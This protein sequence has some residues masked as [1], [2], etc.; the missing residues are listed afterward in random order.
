MSNIWMTW[1]EV[2]NVSLQ[3][4]WWG[5]IQFAPKLILAIIFFVIGWIL[6]SLITK[7]FEQVFSAL[8]IDNLFKSLGVDD[9]F[10]KAGMNLNSGHFVGEVMKWF[11]IIIFLL[12]S[13]NLIGLDSIAYFLK[14]DV[15]G[16][17]PRIVIAAFVLIIA[18]MVADFLSK[19][20][21]ASARAMNLKSS[22]MLSSLVKYTVWVFAFIIALGQLGVAEGYMSILF[23]GII[24]MLAIGGAL[25]FGLGGK[26]A[27]A[28]LISKLGEEMSHRE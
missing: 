7:A 28:R 4:L 8:K 20:A 14:D 17:L 16:F 12:P 3:G 27:A 13:L 23:T 1:G 5:F 6:G 15:L 18:T 26:D 24:G 10:R 19:T 11:I 21:Y 9:F 25:A 22:H 2:F